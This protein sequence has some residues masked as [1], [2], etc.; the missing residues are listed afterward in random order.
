MRPHRPL[1]RPAEGFTLI[2]V[3]VALSIVAIAL[4]AGVQASSALTRNAS[5]QADT[6]LAHVCAENE[7][8]KVRLSRQMP[9]VGDSTQACEQAGR[10]LQVSVAVR[11]TPNPSFRRVDAQ[12]L[13][14]QGR[15]I[16]KLSTVVGRW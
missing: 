13:D 5:R 12:A 9:S 16:V 11:P 10:V 1:W 15:P 2:E 6:L 7:L 3:L 14:E 8:V 4:M